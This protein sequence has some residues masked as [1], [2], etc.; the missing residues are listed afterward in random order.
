MLVSWRPSIKVNFAHRNIHNFRQGSFRDLPN[1]YHNVWTFDYE[2]KGKEM[3]DF[4][5]LLTI[6]SQIYGFLYLIFD[7]M[8]IDD[9]NR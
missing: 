5:C 4:D 3:I 7:R 2:A 9:A 6:N 1:I 8:N